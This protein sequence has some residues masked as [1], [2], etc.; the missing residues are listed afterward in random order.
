MSGIVCAIRG[1]PA[2][3]PTISHAITLAQETALPLHFLY[4]VNLDFLARTSLSRVHVVAQEMQHMGEFILLSAQ[5]AASAQRV[6][7]QGTVRHGD[8]M[9]E[10]IKLCHEL[11][12]D[13]VVLGH[14]Q[15]Q[16]N[17][18]LFTHDRLAQFVKKIEELTGAKVVMAQAGEK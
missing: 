14:P 13:Y 16:H 6:T 9:E 8:V 1:G 5:T 15:V 11:V 2:S 10:I 17:E 12:A 7:A 18:S 3:Q 4:V